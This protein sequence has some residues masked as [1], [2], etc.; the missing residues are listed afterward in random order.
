MI[1][2]TYVHTYLRI[3]WYS[4]S[5]GFRSYK[6]KDIKMGR[7]YEARSTYAPLFTESKCKRRVRQ[8]KNSVYTACQL[9]CSHTRNTTDVKEKPKRRASTYMYSDE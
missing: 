2:V 6:G 8:W 3:I 1:Y 4:A 9:V 5:I 7:N